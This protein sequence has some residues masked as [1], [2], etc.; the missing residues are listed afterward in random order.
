M[1]TFA[2]ITAPVS[3]QSYEKKCE[4][5]SGAHMRNG[6]LSKCIDKK[7]FIEVK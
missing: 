2:F 3:D 6:G 1:F 7:S 5:A 4:T